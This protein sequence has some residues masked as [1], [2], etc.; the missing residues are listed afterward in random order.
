MCFFDLEKNVFEKVKLSDFF[1]FSKSKLMK[2]I[3]S[4]CIIDRLA[5]LIEKSTVY[6]YKM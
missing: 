3:D 2:K 6:V 4:V 1:Q 5:I